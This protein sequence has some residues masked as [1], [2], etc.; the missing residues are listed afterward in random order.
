MLQQTNLFRKPNP[1]NPLI[2]FGVKLTFAVLYF[3]QIKIISFTFPL[4][5]RIA[6]ITPATVADKKTNDLNKIS[7]CL[8]LNLNLK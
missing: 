5:V 4:M 3:L 1:I 8:E 6:P 7:K 2:K